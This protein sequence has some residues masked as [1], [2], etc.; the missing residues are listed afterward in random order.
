[1]RSGFVHHTADTATSS[2][3]TYTAAEVPALIR[4]M[5]AY[6]VQTLGWDDIGYNFLIDR[7]GRTWEGRYGGGD[8]QAKQVEFAQTLTLQL[9]VHRC[10]GHRQL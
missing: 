7:F 6:H 8:G 5:Y 1:M 2:A 3:N 4:G 10:R 9:E